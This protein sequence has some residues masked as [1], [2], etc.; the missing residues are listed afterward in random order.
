MFYSIDSLINKETN[1][2]TGKLCMAETV[3]ELRT[4]FSISNTRLNVP[5]RISVALSSHLFGL[6]SMKCCFFFVFF[7][8]WFLFCDVFDIQSFSAPWNGCIPWL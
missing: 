8:S 1:N 6:I 2:Q 4:T 3:S 5:R 7:F